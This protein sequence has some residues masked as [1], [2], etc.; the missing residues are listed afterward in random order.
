MSQGD[1]QSLHHVLALVSL[2]Q[3]VPA[4]YYD[5]HIVNT[6]ITTIRTEDTLTPE[7]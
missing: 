4:L 7:C 6:F 1:A 2:T 3:C 5:E